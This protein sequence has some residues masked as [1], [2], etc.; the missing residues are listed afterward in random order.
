VTGSAAVIKTASAIVDPSINDPSK[1]DTEC[2][3]VDF[4]DGL[5]GRFEV[6]LGAL[7]DSKVG[8]LLSQEAKHTLEPLASTKGFIFIFKLDPDEAVEADACDETFRA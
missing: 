4:E 2:V 6:F 1:N 3:A 5:R 8:L 7:E